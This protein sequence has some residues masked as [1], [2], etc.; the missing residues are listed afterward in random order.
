MKIELFHDVYNKHV[1]EH[2]SKMKN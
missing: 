1:Y 2:N